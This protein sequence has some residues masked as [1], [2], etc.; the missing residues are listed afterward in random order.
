MCCPAGALSLLQAHSDV[1]ATGPLPALPSLPCP[2]QQQQCER[3][4]CRLLTKFLQEKQAAD[5]EAAL[6]KQRA[7][8]AEAD[9]LVAQL[10]GRV[11]EAR[12][13]MHKAQTGREATAKQLHCALQDVTRMDTRQQDYQRQ[14]Q[15]SLAEINSL[16]QQIE[17]QKLKLHRQE[18]RIVGAAARR[19]LKGAGV[20]LG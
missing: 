10:D 1:N 16:K 9:R 20:L 4:Q 11:V 7:T 14:L 18:K 13:E 6:W 3:C 8:A 15:D 5:A 17:E 19:L 2:A 12:C